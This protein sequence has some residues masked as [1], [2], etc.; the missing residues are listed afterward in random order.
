MSGTSDIVERLKTLDTAH[1]ADAM[2]REGV[3]A[4]EIRCMIPG[5]RMAGVARTARAVPGD[6]DSVL[7]SVLAAAPGEV[8][9]IQY[10][11][12]TEFATVGDLVAAEAK[13]R[14]M[15]GFVV[16]GA[17]R[18]LARLK[19]IGLPVFA[20]G[21]TPRPAYHQT[22]GALQVPIVCG[23]VPI[24]PG[25]YVVGDDDGVVV[26]PR[27][28]AAAVVVEAERIGRLD[29]ERGDAVQAGT[30]LMELPGFAEY[31]KL[32]AGKR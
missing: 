31:L 24:A 1:V 12:I 4:S 7:H 21:T 23:G 20:M 3:M 22:L 5:A 13:R 29:I 16:D 32:F 6:A 17:I 28:R 15:A 9:V 30:P 10:G 18:D 26:I 14:G 25:D 2:L 8:L 27:E 11:R 19:R